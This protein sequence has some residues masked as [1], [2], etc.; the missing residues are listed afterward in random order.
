M[1]FHFLL[2]FSHSAYVYKDPTKESYF[3][4]QNQGF[5]SEIGKTFR[6]LPD[7]AKGVVPDI[8]YTRLQSSASIKVIFYTN[9]PSI[10]IKYD[11]ANMWTFAMMAS[12]GTSGLSLYAHDQDGID[13]FCAGE[14]VINTN[15]GIFSYHGLP[16]D[17]DYEYHL[18]LTNYDQVK[19]LSIGVEEGSTFEFVPTYN[20]RPIICYGT[21]IT[22]GAS[23]SHPAMSWVNIVNRN[24]DYSW[25]NF[26]I[27]GYAMME[28][29][30]IDFVTQEEAKVYVYDCLPNLVFQTVEH[31]YERLVNGVDMTRARYPNVPI[32]L[33]EFGMY[34]QEKFVQKYIDVQNNMKEASTRAWKYFN[35]NNYQ[36]LYLVTHEELNYT[37]DDI[38]DQ[39]HPMDNGMMKHAKALLKPLRQIL[40][41]IENP[42]MTT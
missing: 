16:S 36:N 24:L 37:S 26:G 39:V 23:P 5:M 14:I 32:V 19:S 22:H 41:L 20:E 7:R 11:R 1:I 30:V 3:V 18:F 13:H 29:S 38:S 12:T 42:S 31:T 35:D 9:S 8:V 15:N 33:V 2:T 17:H 6:R 10:D 25:H 34:T 27:M 40:G 28:D 4:N 21:S